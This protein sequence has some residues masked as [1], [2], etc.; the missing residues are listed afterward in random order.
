MSSLFSE[1][2][3]TGIIFFIKVRCDV[4]TVVEKVRVPPTVLTI[5]SNTEGRAI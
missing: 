2:T 4:S 1:L 5:T 3:N